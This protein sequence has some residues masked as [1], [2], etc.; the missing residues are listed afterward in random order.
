[1]PS[2]YR[3]DQPR[4]IGSTTLLALAC[5]AL[6][7]TVT[8]A[9]TPQ[10]QDPD[11]A[12]SVESWT[13]APE[14]ISPLVDHLPV[15]E[16]VPSPK[17]VL[18][19]HVGAPRE[20]TYYA[21]VLEYYRALAAASPRVDVLTIGETD[22]GREYV[23]ELAYRLAAEDSPL[24]NRIRDEVIVT[25]T[26][27]ADPD[28]RDRYVDWYYRH[29]IDIDDD[30]DRITGP[31]YWGRYVFHDNNRDINYSQVTFRALLEWYLEWHPPILHDLHESVPFL[32]TFSGQ[33]P[34]NPTLDPI[35]YGDLPTR[36]WTGRC[37]TTPTT[38]RLPC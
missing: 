8:S 28:G 35:L 38:C 10:A 31:P 37:G 1:M 18:G 26:P 20:L 6:L 13:T 33:A 5:T 23:V 27:V 29:L 25:L 11:F 24:I 36:R 16:G 34:Q 21:Q 12:T 14:F 7:A 30:R 19:H 2:V 32:Y 4:S 3:L 22:E 15:V 9:Q 17:A